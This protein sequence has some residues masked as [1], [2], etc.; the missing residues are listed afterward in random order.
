MTQLIVSR[1]SFDLPVPDKLHESTVAVK[2]RVTVFTLYDQ[3]STIQT[4]EPIPRR[5][6][7]TDTL[8]RSGKTLSLKCLLLVINS[9]I[10]Y[11]S[12]V[13][14]Y[15]LTIAWNRFKEVL[16]VSGSSSS[17]PFLTTNPDLHF[18]LPLCLI[19]GK[20]ALIFRMFCCILTVRSLTRILSC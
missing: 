17:T 5:L 12:S 14:F 9:P 1:F 6:T 2:C 16:W 18:I 19:S 8:L 10:F 7:A 15:S 20:E 13:P 11:H 3:N 4:I